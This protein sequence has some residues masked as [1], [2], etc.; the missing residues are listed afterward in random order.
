M[1]DKENKNMEKVELENKVCVSEKVEHKI[2]I[3]TEGTIKKIYK[4]NNY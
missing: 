2:K 1:N 3:S 4:N